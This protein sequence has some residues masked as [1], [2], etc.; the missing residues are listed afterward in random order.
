MSFKLLVLRDC[1]EISVNFWY[2]EIN[3]R[4]EHTVYHTPNSVAYRAQLYFMY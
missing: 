4:I 1:N 2:Q 3:Q